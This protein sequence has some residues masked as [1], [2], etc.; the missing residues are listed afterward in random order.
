M[1]RSIDL[2]RDWRW[3]IESS[4]ATDEPNSAY[5]DTHCGSYYFT[6]GWG[7]SLR[8]IT[9]NLVKTVVDYLNDYGFTI[10]YRDT[11]WQIYQQA[12][13]E[14]PHPLFCLTDYRRRSISIVPANCDRQI[15]S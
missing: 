9:P 14:R 11:V 13:L 4:T 12:I 3:G 5:I 6:R 1:T 7:C 8:D 10:S 2:T 15:A